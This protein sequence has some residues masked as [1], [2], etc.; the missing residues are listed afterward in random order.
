MKNTRII[1]Q[2]RDGSNNKAL[3]EV[4]FAGEIALAECEKIG[5][6]LPSA[7]GDGLGLFIPGQIGLK[8]LQNA[9]YDRHIALGEAL[10]GEIDPAAGDMQALLDE[11]RETKPIWWPDDGP[12]HELLMID[13]VS[14]D[15]TDERSAAEIAKALAE[16]EWDV[17]YLPPFHAEMLENYEDHMRSQDGAE[18]E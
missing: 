16:T 3:H 9:F 8:D 17:D 14:M 12:F 1:Y 18:P 6:S 5:A 11:M 7:D 13:H 4:V 10:L 2:Y 15:P